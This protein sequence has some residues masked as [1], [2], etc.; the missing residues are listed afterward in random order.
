LSPQK[1][2]VVLDLGAGTGA[3]ADIISNYSDEVFSLEP[4]ATKVEYST[5][6]HQRVKAFT[7][8]AE[9]IPF[10]E[11]YFGKI[12]CI[13]ALHHF[14][15]ASRSLGECERILKPGGVLVINEHNPNARRGLK[16]RF[17]ELFRGGKPSGVRFFAPKELTKVVES[18]GFQVERIVES[19]N[20]YFLKAI[21]KS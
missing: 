2:D 12:Y 9:S 18:A 10:P 3:I 6:K 14:E 8:Q 20:S 15:D 11:S 7:A 13:M 17:I 19:E 21:K 4:Q 1:S 5:R 16:T